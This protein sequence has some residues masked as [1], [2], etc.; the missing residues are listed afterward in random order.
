MM[1]AEEIKINQWFISRC[2]PAIVDGKPT[3]RMNNTREIVDCSKRKEYYEK[4]AEN[5]E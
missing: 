5:N 2:A 1:S 4:H 3:F